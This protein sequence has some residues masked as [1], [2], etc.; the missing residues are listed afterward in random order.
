MILN[1]SIAK[2][3]ELVYSCLSEMDKFAEVH[4]VVYKV[5][6]IGEA[7]FKF[8]EKIKFAFIPFAFNY[9]VN[10]TSIVPNKYVEMESN[11]QKGVHLQLKF[12]LQTKNNVTEVE[13]II[14]IK[15]NFLVRIL[16]QNTIKRVHK[17][18]FKKIAEL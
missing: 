17:K 3:I 18:L 1:H 6:K 2:P 14:L 12:S 8:Y 15:A 13:E 7:E 16:F 10:L 5:E 4:P 9:K 11:V